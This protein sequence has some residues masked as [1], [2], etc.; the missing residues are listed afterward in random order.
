MP[1]PQLIGLPQP[2]V[3]GPSHDQ[4]DERPTFDRG[5]MK[6]VPSLGESAVLDVVIWRG[7]PGGFNQ[8]EDAPKIKWQCHKSAI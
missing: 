2:L 1:E 8:G 3:I 4:L 6:F 7:R 5:R